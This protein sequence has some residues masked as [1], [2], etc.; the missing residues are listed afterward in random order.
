MAR[1]RQTK[2]VCN[3]CNNEMTRGG[4][5]R[6]LR[7]CAQRL[8]KIRQANERGHREK[9]YHLQAQDA[10][11]LGHWLQLEMRGRAT[12]EDLDWYLHLISFENCIMSC[13]HFR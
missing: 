3:Y 6:H 13:L 4:M 8:N 12:L 9:Q 5:T 11:G 10:Y 7:D 1:S 2:G